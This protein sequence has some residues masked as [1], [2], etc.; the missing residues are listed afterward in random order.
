MSCLELSDSFEPYYDGRTSFFRA[1]SEAAAEAPQS[2]RDKDRF[3]SGTIRDAIRH[4][5]VETP[6]GRR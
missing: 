6:S 5:P 4:K 3:G 2:L 1:G